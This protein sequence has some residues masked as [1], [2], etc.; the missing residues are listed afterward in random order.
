[1]IIN[2]HC[3]MFNVQGVFMNRISVLLFAGLVILAM[4]SVTLPNVNSYEAG[5]SGADVDG[6]G[7]CTCHEASADSGVTAKLEGLPANYTASTDY[8]IA[9]SMTG[10]PTPGGT[11]EGGFSLT[12]SIGTLVVT[13]KDETQKMSDGSLTHKSAGNDMR[14]WEAK[15]TAPADDTKQAEFKL[16]VNAVDGDGSSDDGDDWNT[17]TKKVPGQ[18]YDPNTG[19]DDDDDDDSPGFGALSLLAAGLIGTLV[20]V[21]RRH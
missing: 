1:M 19:G 5:I 11:N 3:F 14:T 21:R 18:N 4:A 13:Q 6:S 9:I 20:M 7:G 8:D 16:W 12:A 17:V 15:W 10:G 2:L